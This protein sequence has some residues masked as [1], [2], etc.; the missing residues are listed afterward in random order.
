MRYRDIQAAGEAPRT[1]SV[2]CRAYLAR[3]TAAR[4]AELAPPAMAWRA[5]AGAPALI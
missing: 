3:L 2:T 1:T 4:P 5:R